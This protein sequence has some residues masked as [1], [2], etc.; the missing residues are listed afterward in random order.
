MYSHEIQQLMELRNFLITF[1]DYVNLCNTSPQITGVYYDYEK[2]YF[3]I[4]TTDN[5]DWSF[6]IRR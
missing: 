5:Y 2:D 1:Q 4:K 6:K 3:N